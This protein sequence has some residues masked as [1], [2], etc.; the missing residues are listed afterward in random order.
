MKPDQERVKHLISDTVALLCKN[1][2]QFNKG[3]R[4]QGLLGVT[5]DEN[6]VFLI[7][8]NETCGTLIMT[9]SNN[10]FHSQSLQSSGTPVSSNR[11]SMKSKP[12]RP[13]RPTSKFGHKFGR[14]AIVHRQ[15]TMAGRQQGVSA[16]TTA[17]MMLEHRPANGHQ[18]VVSW[19]RPE[20][21]QHDDSVVQI[22]SED[23]DVVI[24]DQVPKTYSSQTLEHRT[25]MQ[26]E[27]SS[28][29]SYSTTLASSAYP[30]YFPT[31]S[32]H[33]VL[34]PT[35]SMDSVLASSSD[36]RD[37][38]FVSSRSQ[39]SQLGAVSPATSSSSPAAIQSSSSSLWDINSIQTTAGSTIL[40]ISVAGAQAV[41]P[42]G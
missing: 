39:Y 14:E 5:V 19:H 36:A 12:S 22:K 20:H 3:V 13:Q 15:R 41:P 2:L 40:P 32:G 26:M 1:G 18:N 31:S 17:P 25:P 27:S 34:M 10:K 35:Q 33:G 42:V 11:K 28:S 30:S 29:G 4:I 7:P 23:N 37:K 9:T 16:S 24:I 6:D 8:V 38:A 21:T